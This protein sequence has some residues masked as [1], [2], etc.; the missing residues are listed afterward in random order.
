MSKTASSYCL[1]EK[2]DVIVDAEHIVFEC[3]H[4]QNYR[5]VLTS[6]IETIRVMTAIR[7][8]GPQWRTTHGTHSKAEEE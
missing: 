7:K 8:I 4:W 2:G 5:S 6:V 3:A 1:Y